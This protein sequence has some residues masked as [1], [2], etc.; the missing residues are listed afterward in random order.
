VAPLVVSVTICKE[1]EGVK[2]SVPPGRV[3]VMTWVDPGNALTT[4][5]PK[6]DSCETEYSVAV[7]TTVEVMVVN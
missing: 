5:G 4:V 6:Y 2:N 3:Y 1:A 7:C